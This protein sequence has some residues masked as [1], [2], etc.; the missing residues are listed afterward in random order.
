[1]DHRGEACITCRRGRP[2]AG[3]IIFRG[4]EDIMYN[5]IASVDFYDNVIAPNKGT[6]EEWFVA[7]KGLYVYF[8]AIVVT[9][10]TLLF[11]KNNVSWKVF[12]GL[13]Q[14]PTEL[15]IALHYK[16]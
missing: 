9:F 6:L 4:A 1:M 14:P 8:M 10:W 13:P 12:K 2:G 3:S 5:A 15:N 16:D 7:N 11:P